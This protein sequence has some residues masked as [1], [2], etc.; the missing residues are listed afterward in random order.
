MSPEQQEELH[1]LRNE[2]VRLTCQR[3]QLLAACRIGLAW[4][5]ACA[6]R[7]EAKGESVIALQ[8]AMHAESIRAA[9]ARA[10]GKDV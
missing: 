9:I 6:G 10:E 1:S 3:E 5:I 4:T 8:G 7:A 2:V